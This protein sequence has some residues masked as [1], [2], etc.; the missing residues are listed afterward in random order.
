MI[1][2]IVRRSAGYRRVTLNNPPINLFDPEMLS[3]LQALV[4]ELERDRD[5]KVVVFDS[6]D[7]EYF[8]AHL[9]IVRAN[10]FSLEPGPTGLPPWPDVARR[11]EQA[12]F[13][14]V[15]LLRGRARGVGSEFLQAPVAASS[16][17]PG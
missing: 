6:A 12:A 10:E 14:T 3:E 11:L 17:C 15:G 13:V 4:G 2:R 9:D 5:V 16:A 1:L 7:P 8:M